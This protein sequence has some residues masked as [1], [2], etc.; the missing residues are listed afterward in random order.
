MTIY[1][2]DNCYIRDSLL[3][4][5]VEYSGPPPV[6]FDEADEP[7]MTQEEFDLLWAV[8]HTY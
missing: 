6:F 4:D 2:P 5:V 3:G 7:G 1:V 8:E